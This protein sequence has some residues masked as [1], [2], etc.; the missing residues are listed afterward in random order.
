MHPMFVR[1]FIETDA[2][3]LLTEEQ[4]RKRRAHATRR[5]HSPGH[6]GRRPLIQIA[7]AAAEASAHSYR[8]PIARVAAAMRGPGR[9]TRSGAGR[10]GLAVMRCHFC[11]CRSC[12]PL[13]SPNKTCVVAGGL[14]LCGLF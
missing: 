4:D 1:L 3:D 2:D 9:R 8:W 13:N 14:R 7:R 6:E 5:G 12:G 11:R 10:S